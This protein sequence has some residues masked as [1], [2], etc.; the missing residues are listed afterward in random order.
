[1]KL[2]GKSVK[3]G[4]KGRKVMLL[5]QRPKKW[6]RVTGK[7]GRLGRT[8]PRQKKSPTRMRHLDMPCAETQLAKVTASFYGADVL[9][10]RKA[11]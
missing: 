7:D 1:M 5:A 8:L 9:F 11:A 2:L 4:K 6:G 3:C 10:E